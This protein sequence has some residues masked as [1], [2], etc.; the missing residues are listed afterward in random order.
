MFYVN[1]VKKMIK[2]TSYVNVLQ[3]KWHFYL[4]KCARNFLI[5]FIQ[6]VQQRI[7]VNNYQ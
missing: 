4:M 3:L 1:D 2:Y 5:K 7:I 6:N